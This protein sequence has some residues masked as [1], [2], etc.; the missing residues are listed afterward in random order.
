VTCGD[1][2]SAREVR[3]ALKGILE[4]SVLGLQ[5]LLHTKEVLLP[6]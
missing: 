4:Q 2:R 3:N 1:G 6:F 5:L